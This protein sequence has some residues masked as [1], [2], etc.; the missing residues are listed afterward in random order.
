MT[1]SLP[2]KDPD[3]VVGYQYD[4]SGRIGIVDPIVTHTLAV[5]PDT[6][7]TTVLA[8]VTQ[9]GTVISFTLSGGENGGTAFYL[10]TI[11]TAS[12][13]TLEETLVIGIRPSAM[14]NAGP[15][16]ST[17]RQIVE[18]AYE[19]C[20]LSNYE[21]QLQPEELAAALRRLDAMMSQWEASSIYINYNF[22]TQFGGGDLDNPSGIPDN[23]VFAAAG[24]L[25]LLIAPMFGKTISAEVRVQISAA[26][27]SLRAVTA[28]PP[29]RVLQRNTP[30]GAGNKPWSIWNPY[31][32][33]NG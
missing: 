15:S 23:A 26:M 30:V 28:F 32:W 4:W 27:T 11:T 7:T 3:E 16:T 1:T 5:A 14:I 31:A 25:A 24:G 9:V 21:F 8:N 13:L 33:G 20:G 2:F 17:K 18:M 22:P 10:D 19:N 12:G 6:T 29:Q